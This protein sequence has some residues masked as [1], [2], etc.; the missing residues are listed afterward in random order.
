MPSLGVYDP[1]D[2]AENDRCFPLRTWEVP[3]SESACSL[4]PTL[5]ARDGKDLSRTTAYLA[6]R[7]R[8]TPSF[9]TELLSRGWHW[10]EIAGA[11]EA[12]MGFPSRWSAVE[13]T[14]S[15]TPSSRKSRKSSGGGSSKST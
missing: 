7:A 10:T 9:V 4:W 13:S 15:A 2:I 11:C 3:R 8:H 5:N 6:A 14:P 12:L 1:S